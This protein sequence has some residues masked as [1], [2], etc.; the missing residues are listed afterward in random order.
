MRSFVRGP[1]NVCRR[2]SK[3]GLEMATYLLLEGLVPFDL[4]VL[5]A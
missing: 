2:G 5:G 1:V 3:R 4:I